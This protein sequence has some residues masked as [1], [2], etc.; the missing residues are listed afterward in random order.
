MRLRCVWLCVAA[1]LFAGSPA[2][3]QGAGTSA[4]LSG[5]VQD[6]QGAAIP[7]ADVV[8]KNNATSGESRAVTDSEGRFT[9]PALN[10]GTYTVTVS[11]QGFKTVVLPDVQILT[12]TPSSVAVKLQ[13]G[14]LEE[15]VVVRGATDVLQTQTAAVQTTINVQ[16]ISSLP[17]TTRTALDYVVNVPGAITQGGNSRGTRINGL[18]GA[19][20]N[21]TLDGVN[22]QDNNNRG[23]AGGQ[24]DGDGF[25]MYIR[26][27]MDSVEEI[28]LSA[29]TPEAVSSGQGAAQI[30]MTTRAGSSKFTGSA[31]DTW[32]N[33]AGTSDAD[34]ATRNDKR[35]WLWRLNTPYWF[36]KRDRPLTP[37]GEQFIDDVRVET[38][39][40]RVGGPLFSSDLTYFFNWEWFK[41]PNQIA[42]TRFLMNENARAGN[43][44]YLAS[45][46]T[47][48][49]VNLFS[50]A[51][52]TPD[53][54]TSKLFSDI[55]SSAAGYTSGQID[56]WDLNTDK[57]DY[58]PGGDNYRHF[59]TG[60]L[61]YNVTDNH[62]LTATARYN[63]FEANPDMLN[64][65][66][67]RFPGF[68]NTAGQYS[69]RYMWQAALR[70]TI[71]KN[72]VNEARYGF[73]GGTSR[74][75]T[76]ATRSTFDCTGL[77]CQGGY[78]FGGT[79]LQIGGGG[80]ALTGATST[81]APSTRYTPDTVVENT[82]TWLKGRHT[83]SFGG[84]YT[85]ITTENMNNPGGLVPAITFGVNSADPAFNQ[86]IETNA[87]AFPGGISATNIGFA[88]NLYA[89]LTGRVTQVAGTFVL[90]DAANYQFLGERW[91]NLSMDE[92]GLFV[93]DSWRLRPNFT[94]TAGLRYELQLPFKPDFSSYSR[95]EDW[96]QIYGVSGPA[97]LFN[98]GTLGGAAPVFVQY[99]Q[100]DFGYNTDYNNFGPSIGATW[101]PRVNG[102]LAKILSAEPVFRGGYS[103]SFDR[104]GTG[105]FTGI[106]GANA[107]ATRTGTRSLTLTGAANLNAD[108][109]GL[110]VLLSDTER[111]APFAAPTL[112]YP[113]TPAAN[114]S[115]NVFHEDIY[116][117][118]THQYSIGW[119]REL[120]KDMAVEIRYIGNQS[121][122]QWTT[123]NLNANANWNIK[124]NG[125]YEEYRVAQ[126]NLAANIAA[127]RGNTFAFTGAP[128][129]APLPIFAAYF[130]GVP[131]GDARNQ[132]P[133]TYASANFANSAWYNQL[134][135]YNANITGI[136]GTGTNGLQNSARAANAA[137]AGLPVNF[138]QV[139]PS[140]NQAAANLMENGGTI[141]YDAMQLEL[142]RRLTQGL[143]VQGSYVY[144]KRSNWTRPSLRD[145]FISVPSTGA[146]GGIDHALKFNW[147]Y[148]LPFGKDRRFGGNAGR[149]LNAVIGGWEIDGVAR[150]QSGQRFN[151]GGVR[152]EG[153]SERDV[154]DMF[155]F[156]K[157]PDA[158]GVTRVYM[159]PE[160]VIDQSIIAFN[161][162]SA[163][164]PSGYTNGVVPTGRYF[165]PADS[166]DCV[167]YVAG[168]CTPLSIPISAPWFGKTDMSFVKRF[169]I[170]GSRTV[171]ARMDL[172]NIF[173]NIN[174]TPLGV[175]TGSSRSSWEV[176]G[177][178][179]DVNAS[180]D[181]GGRITSFGLRF[182]W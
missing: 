70:S 82:T 60:R 175:Q 134:A 29:S 92:V 162:W 133:A 54:T 124:E 120:G 96:T 139:N 99:Q 45:D 158:N 80:N 74:F 87:A 5:Q 101:Q 76:D 23:P 85:R 114:E 106:F 154:Q 72:I 61:D 21:I 174:F 141:R 16:Q 179:R 3:A 10:P 93:S 79:I 49:T 56:S 110:P 48:R 9:I 128:G 181:A 2:F 105:E 32:R 109:R 31:Y 51:G 170:G 107:G 38:P 91:Q 11:L 144:G 20:I 34:S 95:L 129:T 18:P 59:P 4:P 167:Q 116:V 65:V 71:G 126:R 117:P 66:E 75:F 108:G 22:V 123:T 53:P 57:F 52:G 86:I 111:L 143:L 156:Y 163:T 94:L 176:T 169:S 63:R 160:D 132:D 14:T 40:F 142:R 19:S 112:S 152:L 180:Q 168:D 173:D 36:N 44:T 153:M 172:Y 64:N 151:I 122:G 145:D 121:K 147:I 25:F 103:M 165:A 6:A 146:V 50:I 119:Q 100:G 33:Q 67:P 58:S 130:H 182:N 73:Q 140:I 15:T 90:D 118:F 8:A 12:A 161:G 81:N 177:A 102:F 131:L 17:L 178:A 28:T 127:G 148:Q 149:W 46:G 43:F 113:I 35:G 83:L 157:R 164:H 88:R 7:G 27:M 42:R 68:V 125:F 98:P 138:F 159:F 84:T 47:T 13:I 30:R 136:A 26:P 137:A 39:G 155:K 97:N 69:H 62:R 135:V 104:Y 78:S 166:P 24:T 171:E 89:M 1:L 77:G 150:F 115:V 55:R 41:W 37:A